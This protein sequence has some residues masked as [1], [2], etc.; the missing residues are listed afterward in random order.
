M[1]VDFQS[2]PSQMLADIGALDFVLLATF[3]GDD[4]DFDAA[5]LANDRH[6]VGNGAGGGAAA[7]PANHHVVG[8][9]RRLLNVRHHDH[10]TPGLEQGSLPDDLLNNDD[11]RL[12]LADY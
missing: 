9:E 3:A 2:M 11:V 5:G 8:F 6:R 10:R 12:R 1:D 7:V 4:D